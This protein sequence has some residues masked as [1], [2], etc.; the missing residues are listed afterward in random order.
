M[1]TTTYRLLQNSFEIQT[2]GSHK[3]AV[4]LTTDTTDKLRILSDPLLLAIY[5]NYLPHHDAYLALNAAVE[6]GEGTYKGKTLSFEI[7][8]DSVTG[9]LRLWEPPIRTIFP[10]DSPTEIEIFPNK[11]NP[12]L[13]GTYEQ[14]LQAVKV[15]R[16]K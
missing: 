14:R 1:A 7:I 12:F 4:T 11:R 3:K 8:I 2:R 6:M 15:L 10:E 9:K 5:N 13:D 16:D